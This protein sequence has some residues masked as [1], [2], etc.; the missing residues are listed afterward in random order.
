M[1]NGIA[2]KVETDDIAEV[3]ATKILKM[4]EFK[5]LKVITPKEIRGDAGAGAMLDVSAEAMKQRRH[6]GFYKEGYHFWKKSDRIVM[7]DRDALLEEWRLNNDKSQT[8]V[9]AQ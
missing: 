9:T 2:L 6:T 3:V 7:W 4:L 8:I 5:L 1:S